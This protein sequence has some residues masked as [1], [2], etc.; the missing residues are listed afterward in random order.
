[1]ERVM[2]PRSGR[3]FRFSDISLELLRERVSRIDRKDAEKLILRSGDMRSDENIARALMRSKDGISMSK[4]VIAI[5][6]P[7]IPIRTSDGFDLDR[8]IG[9]LTA[10]CLVQNAIIDAKR[11][12][13]DVK[14]LFEFLCTGGMS[15]MRALSL[16]NAG[17][18][19]IRDG[20]VL[21]TN[22]PFIFP[23]RAGEGSTLQILMNGI[24]GRTYDPESFEAK[25]FMVGMG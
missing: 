2:Q 22:V 14:E 3:F 8:E 12:R 16:G 20:G 13:I 25:Q 7:V 4:A 11:K 9:A 17:N 24:I 6:N 23:L 18:A 5:A 1:M 15:T 21:A 19:A 10:N